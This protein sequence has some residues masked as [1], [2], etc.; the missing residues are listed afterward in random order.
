M[1]AQRGQVVWTATPQPTLAQ[2]YGLSSVEYTAAGEPDD[3]DHE[4][5]EAVVSRFPEVALILGD[6]HDQGAGSLCIT[7][8]YDL[9]CLLYCPESRLAPSFCMSK[10]C[11][12]AVGSVQPF[13]IASLK[14]EN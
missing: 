14:V 2:T 3:L 12:G 10:F 8:R 4:D 13:Y 7:N 9:V 6:N 1:T 11:A 5:G